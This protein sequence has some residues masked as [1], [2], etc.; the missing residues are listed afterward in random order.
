MTYVFV[1]V[2]NHSTLLR[3]EKKISPSG[4]QS[5]LKNLCM[6]EKFP[7]TV[8]YIGDKSV[9]T[10]LMRKREIERERAQNIGTISPKD[11]SRV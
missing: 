11:W 1:A 4:L 3:Y 10:E 9:G 5:P 6:F 7:I 8:C 2:D